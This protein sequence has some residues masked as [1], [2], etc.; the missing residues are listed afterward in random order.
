LVRN[1]VVEIELAE[2]AISKMQ[3]HFLA[4]PALMANAVAV[5]DQEHPDHQIDRGPTEVAPPSRNHCSRASST[6]FST[7]SVKGGA[8]ARVG[9]PAQ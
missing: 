4:Q 9:S 1:L 3:R 2:P 5:A 7:A 8:S 6:S